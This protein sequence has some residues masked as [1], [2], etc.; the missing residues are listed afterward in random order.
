VSIAHFPPGI[1][2]SLTNFNFLLFPLVVIRQVDC[3]DY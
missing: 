1:P 3:S 2:R